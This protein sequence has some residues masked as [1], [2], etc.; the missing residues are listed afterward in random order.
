MAD[1]V[2]QRQRVGVRC[3]SY[4]R[5]IVKSFLFAATLFA[6]GINEATVYDCGKH[7]FEDVRKIETVFFRV[8]RQSM[9]M[10]V[11]LS[12]RQTD[13]VLQPLL[14]SDV[15]KSYE[16]ILEVFCSLRLMFL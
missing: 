1:E 15:K 4:V 12:L 9:P 7:S 16:Q 3:H 2:L 14:T 6:A 13:G 10:P 11:E 5:L 8:R